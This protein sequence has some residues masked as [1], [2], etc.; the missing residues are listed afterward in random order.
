MVSFGMLHKVVL[1]F[2]SL[3]AILTCGHGMKT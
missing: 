3:S 1:I 2:E